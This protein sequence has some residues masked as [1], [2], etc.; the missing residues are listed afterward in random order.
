MKEE[1]E[2]SGFLL[3]PSSFILS[4]GRLRRNAS[5]PE[6]RGV[7]PSGHAVELLPFNRESGVARVP[8]TN[9][10]P[11][12]GVVVVGRS[13]SVDDGAARQPDHDVRAIVIVGI[14]GMVGLG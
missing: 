2:W 5:N 3:H 13:L 7:R 9:D 4:T 10:E 12:G 11:T 1:P 8:L 14:F 6:N